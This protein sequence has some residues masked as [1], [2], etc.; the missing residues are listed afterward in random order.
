M[1]TRKY[2]SVPGGLPGHH[3]R[4]HRLRR[5]RRRRRRLRRQR[6]HPRPHRHPDVRRRLCGQH[7]THHGGRRRHRVR[8][9]QR[10]GGLLAAARHRRPAGP[11]HQR[12]DTIPFQSVPVRSTNVAGCTSDH[13]CKVSHYCDDGDNSCQPIVCDAPNPAWYFGH[14]VAATKAPVVVGDMATFACPAR[15]HLGASRARPHRPPRPGRPRALRRHGRP[16]QQQ[17]RPRMEAR[18]HRRPDQALRKR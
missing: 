4:Q 14:L 6:P 17:P 5:R 11:L 3:P 7:R 13:V 12:Y 8:R 1:L 18:R 9:A 16:V 2:R 15:L 10:Q